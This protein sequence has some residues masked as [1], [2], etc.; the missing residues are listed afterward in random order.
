MT[1]KSLTFTQS[2]QAP[3]AQAYYSFANKSGWLEWFSSKAGGY[4]SPKSVLH[5]MDESDEHNF[6]LVFKQF[7]PDQLV[8]FS[9][10]HLKSM[11]I[12]EVEVAF[13]ESDG[14]VTVTLNQT[15]CSE[16]LQPK[17][18]RLWED[19][20]E[21]LRSVLESGK[22][23]RLWNR[24]F[25][26]VMVKDWVSPESAKQ[27]ALANDYGL[28]ISSVFPNM[29]AEMSG[30]QD[31][32]LIITVGSIPLRTF[33][34]LL[35]AFKDYKAGDR[36][37]I[38]Y[39]RKSEKISTDLLLSA[40]PIPEAPSTAHDMAE[41]AEDFFNRV[42]KKLAAMFSGQS[43]AQAAYKP[44]A[45]EWSA[46]EVLA[47][48]I[49]GMDDTIVWA[50]TT[51]AS[52]E[53][54]PWSSNYPPRLKSVLAIFPTTKDLLKELKNK[55]AVLAALVEEFP[56]EMVN[57][58]GTMARFSMLLSLEIPNHYKDHLA[59]IQTALESAADVRGS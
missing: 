42:D 23:L 7:T 19:R 48:L 4:V 38:E 2:I 26:G 22:D 54:V 13:K 33:E 8:S 45:G 3:L 43:E 6:A 31:G 49:A 51:A 25:L 20:L 28:L 36:V 57:R 15:G 40:Y 9:L 50:G 41:K 1:T 5:L 10:I 21:N 16:S 37:P 34:D 14:Q 59:Q 18:V 53:V 46:K 47:H 35:A 52:R 56:T 12:S 55:H 39:Y 44:A 58:K 32:D 27:E 24:P 11:E 29:G 17:M 30:L